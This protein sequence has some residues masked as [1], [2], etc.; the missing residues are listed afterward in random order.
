MKNKK[1]SPQE[2]VTLLH[3]LLS[4]KV[5]TEALVSLGGAIA[6]LNLND[7]KSVG[8]NVLVKDLK[9]IYQSSK[10]KVI[11]LK[12]FK[13][14]IKEEHPSS[15]FKNLA[16]NS[17]AAI[18]G[19]IQNAKISIP[20][21]KNRLGDFSKKI[22][23]DYNK[24]ENNEDRGRYILKLSLYASIFAMAFNRGSKQKML[25][26]STIPLIVLGM[27]L[28]V[29]NR[30]LEQA[31][32]KLGDNK[33]AQG[34]ASDLRSLLRTL[35]MGFSSGMTLNVVV[36]GIVDQKIEISDLDG[37]TIGSLMPKSIIDNMIYATL[38]GLFSTEAKP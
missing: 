35:N 10:K 6:T 4:E 25:S 1:I 33:E 2:F 32:E 3:K 15:F 13:K 11:S 9:P 22:I 18:K 17:A 5:P 14:N 8:G 7:W 21:A 12:E 38:M 27:T 29:I 34:L 16:K 28:V 36:D 24:L 31:E 23:T 30:V 19:S 37:K 26:K 20:E